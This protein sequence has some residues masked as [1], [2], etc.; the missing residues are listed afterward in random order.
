MHNTV[1][2]LWNRHARRLGFCH[3][4]VSERTG[5]LGQAEGYPIARLRNSSTRRTHLTHR[6]LMGLLTAP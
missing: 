2:V 5:F 6:G 4:R 1:S 3:G